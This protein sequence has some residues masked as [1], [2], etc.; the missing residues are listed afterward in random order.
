MSS[1]SQAVG[2]PHCTRFTPG[3]HHPTHA[4][5]ETRWPSASEI[6]PC[7]FSAVAA[8]TIRST[9][10][11]ITKRNPLALAGSGH[12]RSFGNSDRDQGLSQMQF[13]CATTRRSFSLGSLHCLLDISLSEV[14]LTVENSLP[15]KY[16]LHHGNYNPKQQNGLWRQTLRGTKIDFEDKPF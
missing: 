8:E 4:G 3:S 16:K 15:Y 11:V 13:R 5:T 14:L 9:T 7:L 6:P 12:G 10:C 1:M 2:V